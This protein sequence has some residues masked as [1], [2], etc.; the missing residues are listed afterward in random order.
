MDVD[1]VDDLAGRRPGSTRAKNAEAV[2]ED[3]IRSAQLG[4]ARRS[5]AFSRVNRLSSADSGLDSVDKGLDLAS[6]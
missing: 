5:A 6:I 3:L 2:P 1:V 4:A